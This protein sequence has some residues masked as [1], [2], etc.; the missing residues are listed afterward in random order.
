MEGN[1]R[2]RGS[3]KGKDKRG[4]GNGERMERNERKNKSV[5]ENEKRGR[6]PGKEGGGERDRLA[7]WE[8]GRGRVGFHLDLKDS[9]S[10]ISRIRPTD[11]QS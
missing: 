2:K 4:D 7:E 8:E 5:D 9:G 3:G 1:K 6:W 11:I 10:K